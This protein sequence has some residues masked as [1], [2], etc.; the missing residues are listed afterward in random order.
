MRRWCRVVALLLGTGSALA[1]QSDDQSYLARRDQLLQERSELNA[2]VWAQESEAQRHEN[3]LVQLWDALLEI[4]RQGKGDKA[5]VFKSLG[6]S[7]VTL[8]SLTEPR[9]LDHGIS[10]V[11]LS[12]GKNLDSTAWHAWLDKLVAEGYDLIQSE[13]HHATFTQN[14]DGEAQSTVTIVLHLVQQATHTRL[15]IEGPITVAWAPEKV[16]SSVPRATSVDCSKL[17]ILTR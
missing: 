6:L 2:T 12:P 13:W 7:E 8:G 10:I 15:S 4:N 3:S 9:T 1:Q 16:K 11:Q 14:A 17:R 5:A